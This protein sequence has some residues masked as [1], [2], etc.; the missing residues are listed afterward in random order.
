MS[1]WGVKC[2]FKIGD[3]LTGLIFWILLSVINDIALLE[4]DLI[5][6][7]AHN[8]SCHLENRVWA[9]FNQHR[10]L[11]VQTID[12]NLFQRQLNDSI[13]RSSI[14]NHS[15]QPFAQLNGTGIFELRSF[16]INRLDIRISFH[17]QNALHRRVD[18]ERLVHLLLNYGVVFNLRV[19]VQDCAGLTGLLGV[20]EILIFFVWGVPDEEVGIL[21]DL[22]WGESSL[23]VSVELDPLGLVMGIF[24]YFS[25]F[26]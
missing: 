25:F 5:G 13:S 24:A 1:I 7:C 6:T 10:I 4:V 21:N 8:R 12:L 20:N 3:A 15:F 23:F 18:K 26:Y 9:S 19:V 16:H 22:G 11:D 2:V 14:L 17:S